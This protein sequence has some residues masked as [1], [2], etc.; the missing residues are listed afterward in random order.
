[1]PCAS[2]AFL[3]WAISLGVL[4]TPTFHSAAC[5]DVDVE[6]RTVSKDNN[7]RNNSAAHSTLVFATLLITSILGGLVLLYPQL[8]IPTDTSV[9]I[10]FQDLRSPFVDSLVVGLTQ[11]GDPEVIWPLSITITLYLAFIAK[12]REAAITW[13]AAIAFAA[14]FNSVIKWIVARSRPTALDY[15]GFTAFSFPSGHATVN[16]TLYG[17]A[18]VL[19]WREIAPERRGSAGFLLILF[20]VAIAVSRL[21]LGAHWFSDVVASSMLAIAIVATAYRS[22]MPRRR[23]E[24]HPGKLLAVLGLCLFV[25]GGVHIARNH[26]EDVARYGAAHAGSPA[27]A[28]STA[29]PA[30]P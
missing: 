23:T 5:D 10:R 9:L 19:L 2:G 30:N 4:A 27:P 20:G 15:E 3:F 8:L 18:A 1:M 6:R 16:L 11:L 25:Y 22:Y 26:G 21:Y 14:S 28:A 24:L 17:V 7:G 13:A 29:A 12:S